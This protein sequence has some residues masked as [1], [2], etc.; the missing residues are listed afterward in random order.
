MAEA[1]LLLTEG[2][3]RRVKLSANQ[4]DDGIRIVA[5]MGV[6]LIHAG[7]CLVHCL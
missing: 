2:G 1:L 4:K 5:K 3:S 7:Q 6:G